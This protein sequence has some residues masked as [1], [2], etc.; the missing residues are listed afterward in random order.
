MV[1][2]FEWPIFLAKG[3]VIATNTVFSPLALDRLT[4][5]DFQDCNDFQK[6][7]MLFETH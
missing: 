7:H 2:V 1:A 5:L 6:S 4:Y 3:P